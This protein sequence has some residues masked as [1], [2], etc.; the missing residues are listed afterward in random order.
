MVDLLSMMLSSL[1]AGFR[2]RAVLQAEIIALRHQLMVLQRASLA[3]RLRLDRA[4][5]CLWG[6]LSRWWSG[7]R[8]ALIIVKPATVIG[9]HRQT[10]RWYWTWKSRH[11]KPGRPLVAKELRELIRPHPT[12]L[13]QRQPPHHLHR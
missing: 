1:L 11:G 13:R 6:W 8:S 10:F 12:S 2:R 9:W 3:H 4:D 5:R 7:W